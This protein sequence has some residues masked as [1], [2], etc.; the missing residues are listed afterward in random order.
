MTMTS[1]RL[2]DLLPEVYRAKDA[3]QGW[4][5]RALL[6]VI[7]E[8]VNLVEAD[9][10]QLYENWFIETCQDWVVPYIGDLIGYRPVHE[11]GEPGSVT[12]EGL[13]RNK[14]LIPRRD[15]ADT[16]RNRRRKGTLALLE[17]LAADVAGW[18]ARAVEFFRLLGWTQ[19]LDHQRP[20]RGQTANL[21]NGLALDGL[22]G[23][24][25]E[26]A[27]TV[28]VRR[29]SSHRSPGRYNIPSVGLFVWRLK[30]YSIPQGA[31]RG[32]K[33]TPAYLLEEAGPQCFTFSVLGNDTPLYVRPQPEDEPTHIAGKLNV[34]EPI[35]RREFEAAIT[36]Y[37]GEGK[38]LAIW[39]EWPAAQSQRQ[40][41][42]ESMTLISPEQLVA[43]DLSDW[44]AYRPSSDQVAVDP[45]LGRILFPPDQLPGQVR[46]AYTYAFSA[47]LGGGDY[48]R[49]L[50]Q[51]I[52]ATLYRVGEAEQITSLEEALSQWRKAKPLNAVIEISDSSVYTEQLATIS[53]SAG[54]SLQIRAANGQRPVVRL[55]NWKVNL[56]DALTVQ[57]ES[58][59]RL[60]LDG[61]LITGRGVHISGKGMAPV[62][63]ALCPAQ[64]SIRHCT[65]VPGWGL[66][67]DCRPKRPA[68]PS[69]QLWN[70]RAG[71]RIEH[72]IVGS[73]Q[74][75]EDPVTTDP[76]P[77]FISDSIVD[78]TRGDREAVGAP[79]YQV[80][81]AELTIRRC[82]VFGI[83]DV[84][85]IALAENCIFDDCLNVA[86]RQLGCMRFCYVPSGCR[87]PRRYGCQPDLVE[88]PIEADRQANKIDNAEYER[89]IAQARLGVRPRFNSERYGTPAYCQLAH[90]CAGEIKRGADDESEMGVFHDLYQPQREANLRA[91]LD[92][93]APAGM[94]AGIIYVS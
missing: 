78:A 59:S 86:R 89:R 44:E 28:D 61:L 94:D 82:T 32:L 26:L 54:H 38:S 30:T 40:T 79:G 85:A 52:D 88:R 62:R 5:L 12:A 6:G 48:A 22:G 42:P 18:P 58:G 21:R 57:M 35:G 50:A 1:D 77:V 19:H 36:D 11:A 9:I 93:Y 66:H 87:T 37:Y 90:D 84:H 73:I 45:E 24:F 31:P 20:A 2:Y 56:P 81:H 75:N 17:E 68:E 49:P 14:I 71:V 65:L 70:V 41:W 8:Q 13:A 46:V 51:P 29:I 15:V 25:D 16:I 4:P 23:P 10:A 69:L 91:R 83:V 67:A 64:V 72:S 7:S 47:D 92:E 39:A 27:H 53:L 74:I 43:A 33:G 3:E 60:A 55:E 34:P 63:G 80:A 76:I